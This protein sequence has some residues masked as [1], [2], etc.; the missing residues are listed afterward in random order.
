MQVLSWPRPQHVELT[1]STSVYD[2]YCDQSVSPGAPQ[3]VSLSVFLE[4][5]LDLL[6]WWPLVAA[7]VLPDPIW[8][9]LWVITL[10]ALRVPF[11]LVGAQ[12][13]SQDRGLLSGV[14]RAIK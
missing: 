7:P 6:A 9:V 4:F 5:S 2:V 10:F 14:G 1:A 3:Y 11:C 12:Y 13:S 8:R